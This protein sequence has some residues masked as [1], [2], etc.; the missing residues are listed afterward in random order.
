MRWICPECGA[1]TETEKWIED[2]RCS[3]C[4]HAGL[5]REA[6]DLDWRAPLYDA[7]V[8]AAD[9]GGSLT[10]QAARF[11][12]L[13]G[14]RDSDERRADCLRRLEGAYSQAAEAAMSARTPEALSMA[15]ERMAGVGDYLDSAD[16]A[17]VLREAAEA[18]ERRAAAE[19]FRDK[20]RNRR[21]RVLISLAGTALVMALM[22][23]CYQAQLRRVKLGDAAL[24]A[25]DYAAAE[26]HYQ[27]AMNT[28]AQD[29]AQARLKA[30][31]HA[32]AEA[33]MAAG[34]YAAAAERYEAAGEYYQAR[35]AR[36]ALEAEAEGSGAEN[37]DGEGGDAA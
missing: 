10:G 25:G 37:G 6:I 35:Q 15:A 21:R 24:A 30:L 20:A 33:L 17:R 7:A 28:W 27:D 9:V 22:T 3:L 2:A 18:S 23:G 34:D 19:A 1:A 16:Q 13:G 14:Y 4:G 29:E 31:N 36:D 32:W 8:Q 5:R 11:A 26:A 12:L